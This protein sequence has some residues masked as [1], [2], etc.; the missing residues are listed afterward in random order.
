MVFTPRVNV[1]KL[2]DVQEIRME[3]TIT[4]GRLHEQ[5]HLYV[6]M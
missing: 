5:L 3:Y 4:R 1:V 6:W 2:N